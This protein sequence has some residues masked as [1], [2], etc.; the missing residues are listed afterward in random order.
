MLLWRLQSTTTLKLYI[1]FFFLIS[2]THTHPSTGSNRCMSAVRGRCLSWPA[3][4]RFLPAAAL[5][6]LSPQCEPAAS[7]LLAAAR[8]LRR[9]EAEEGLAVF[10]HTCTS[11]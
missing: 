10:Q 8:L 6:D 7:C 5:C 2:A 9:R 4:D 3:R 1:Y 11:A